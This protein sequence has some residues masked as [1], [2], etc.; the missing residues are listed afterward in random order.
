MAVSANTPEKKQ[1]NIKT[2]TFG[3][4]TWVDITD[5]TEDITKYLTEK[6]NFHPMDIEDALSL[7]QLSKVEEYPT[8][9][10]AIF[11]LLKY[12]K[13]TKVSI[14]KQWS[15]FLGDKYLVTLHPIELTASG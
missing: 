11:H 12:N 4:L 15:A 1:L 2:I 9:I 14:R 6:Y 5:P 13:A 8:Y 10:F 3:D 7:R